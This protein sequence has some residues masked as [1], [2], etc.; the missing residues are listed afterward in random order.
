MAPRCL[1]RTPCALFF[2]VC[3]FVSLDACHHLLHSAMP[4]PRC[5][6]VAISRFSQTPSSLMCRWLLRPCT[7]ATLP[8]TTI[9]S[10]GHCTSA[11]ERRPHKNHLFPP[12]T[13]THIPT[14]P[15]AHPERMRVKIINR[16]ITHVSPFPAA[17]CARQVTPLSLMT[18]LPSSS[19]HSHSLHLFLLVSSCPSLSAKAAWI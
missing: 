15:H 10:S 17:D 16:L 19:S 18:C 6:R 11:G 1:P 5:G 4:T 14:G 7:G 13:H 9:S 8:Q 12:Q 2:C 3:M